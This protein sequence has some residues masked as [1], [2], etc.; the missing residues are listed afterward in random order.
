MTISELQR[1]RLSHAALARELRTRSHQIA[2][3]RLRWLSATAWKRLPGEQPELPG[4]A[5]TGADELNEADQFHGLAPI[6]TPAR[7]AGILR[8][9]GLNEMTECALRTRAYRKQI[10]FHIN[11]HRLTFTLAD[12]REIAEG[13]ACR[14]QT[15]SETDKTEPAPPRAERLRR[16]APAVPQVA[17]Q[18]AWRARRPR[19]A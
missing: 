3:E 1:T 16:R 13:R 9:L 14:P 18:N 8:S 19:D 10:P 12:L 17:P 11:G 4:G 5:M 6:F 2:N 7:A 15:P